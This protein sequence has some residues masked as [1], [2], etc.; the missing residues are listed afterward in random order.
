[1]IIAKRDPISFVRRNFFDSFLIPQDCVLASVAVGPPS[2]LIL[3]VFLFFIIFF[4]RAIF[5]DHLI[6][7]VV[8][9]HKTAVESTHSPFGSLYK[10]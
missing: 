6:V 3:S 10:T 4:V 8:K 2:L 7:T 9:N 1:M 5:P